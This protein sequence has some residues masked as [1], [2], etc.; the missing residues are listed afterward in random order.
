MEAAGKPVN[1]AR[2]LSRAI[3]V[4]TE[5][6]ATEQAVRDLRLAITLNRTTEIAAR[7]STAIASVEHL[8][9]LTTALPGDYTAARLLGVVRQGQDAFDRAC[10]QHDTD[11]VT[12]CGEL[13]GDAVMNYAL[14]L[15]SLP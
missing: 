1:P 9:T 7:A 2:E 14:Y 13:V 4:R 15:A 3:A 11:S 10:R 6:F 12:W 8:A 5:H